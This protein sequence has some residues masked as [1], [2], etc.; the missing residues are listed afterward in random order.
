MEQLICVVPGCNVRGQ[1]QA[2]LC[3]RLARHCVTGHA[4]K[5]S[6]REAPGRSN[7][8]SDCLGTHCLCQVPQRLRRCSGFPLAACLMHLHACMTAQKHCT[9]R[10]DLAMLCPRSLLPKTS[11]LTLSSRALCLACGEAS[12]CLFLLQSHTATLLS[13]KQLVSSHWCSHLSFCS[14]RQSADSWHTLRL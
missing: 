13:V 3:A 14:D 2:A 7:H 8:K 12:L 10:R 11:P 6:S 9:R 1:T 5:H 4:T